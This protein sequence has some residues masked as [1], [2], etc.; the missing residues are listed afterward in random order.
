MTW[1]DR[2][3]DHVVGIIEHV[4]KTLGVNTSHAVVF[5]WFVI[6]VANTNRSLVF[7]TLLGLDNVS[8]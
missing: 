8:G 4:I 3:T 5:V 7:V 6:V 2:V 1:Y